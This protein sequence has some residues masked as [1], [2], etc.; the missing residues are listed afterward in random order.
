MV[1]PVGI[2][3][4]GRIGRLVLRASLENPECRVVAINEPFMDAEY[5]V[6][7][8]HYD[9]VHGRFKGTVSKGED[10]TLIVNGN[11]IHLFAEKDPANIQWSKA[12]AEYIVES[13]GLFLTNE[14]AGAHLKGGAKKVVISAPSTD[15]PMFVMGVNEETY[16]PSVNILSNASCTTNCLAPLAKVIHENFT[17]VEGLMTTVHAVTATQKTVDGPSGKDWRSGRSAMSN[18]IPATTGAAKA[19]G[20]VIPTLEGKLTGMSLRV[21]NADVSVVDLTCRLEKPATYEQIKKAMKDAAASDKYKRIIA[22]TEDE[23]VSAD[24]IGDTH[25]CVFDAKAGIALNPHFVKLVA[26]Y[27]NE[28]AFYEKTDVVVLNKNNFATTVFGSDHIWLVEFYAPWC[29]HCK[30]LKPEYE[31]AATNLK[32]LV[33]IGAINCDD[34]KELCGHYEIQGFPTIKFFGSDVVP[35]PKQ[36]N[37][38]HKVPENY[39]GGRTASDIA[40]F[41]VGK[42]PSYVTKLSDEASIEKFVTG[43]E[44]AKAILFTD[45][46][47]T[48]NLYKGLSVDFRRSLPLGEVLNAK[49]VKAELL[50]QFQV[51][52]YPTLLVF[53]GQDSK[54]FEKYS[55]K[56]DHPNLFKFLSTHQNQGAAGNK[57]QQQQQQQQQKPKVE[58]VVLDHPVEIKTQEKFDQIC[59]KSGLCAVFLFDQQ[60]PDQKESNEKHIETLNTIAKKYER[61]IKIVYMDGTKE[62]V[63][64]INELNLAGLPNMFVFNPSLMRYSMYLGSY[65][66]E[67]IEQ[68]FESVLLGKKNTSLLS[69]LPKINVEGTSNSK[70][71]VNIKDEL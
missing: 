5:M 56:I 11:K 45:K 47:K 10:N 4:F 63:N 23:V 67:S 69:K 26:W 35:N 8:F 58:E 20:K 70:P 33:K 68:F 48:S 37:S 9:S 3:G 29:G 66:E 49:N 34:E 39:N 6:Y 27:D 14:K 15:A 36:K 24:F 46:A 40:K 30:S 22:Y 38:F 13:T 44:G 57:H 17:I 21:P 61:K 32:G 60:D 18:I 59:G 52:S 7:M 12:G 41:A 1:V 51:T 50:E 2:N 64:F 16:T 19:V 71:K 54:Q 31:K 65:T 53:K 55:G 25:S 42:L 43:K 28:M 62:G